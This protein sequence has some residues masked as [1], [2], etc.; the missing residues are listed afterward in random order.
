MKMRNYLWIAGLGLLASCTGEE[1]SQ[2][3]DTTGPDLMTLNR[4]ETVTDDISLYQKHIQYYENGRVVQQK[5]FGA[6]ESLL[7]HVE[8]EFTSNSK[9]LLYYHGDSDLQSK[10]I[11]TYD[12][13]GK[14]TNIENQDP[15]GSVIGTTVVTYNTD[16]TI[17]AVIAN[18][19]G[20]TSEHLYTVNADG[21][22]DTQVSHVG[23]DYSWT[24][25][26]T[27]DGTKPVSAVA[28]GDEFEPMTT[29]FTYYGQAIPSNQVKTVN[30]INN[31]VF[32]F[33]DIT[34]IAANCNHY[35][36]TSSDNVLG[37]EKVF[38]ALGYITET[39]STNANIVT[40]HST[41]FYNE[42]EATPAE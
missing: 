35:L 15:S 32:E 39:T 16:G 10:H 31:A 1:L 18:E 41:Y 30:Q 38:N 25:T 4:I 34:A 19:G 24:T 33:G 9:T 6:D 37:S 17:T 14:L 22:I 27:Y 42:D 11:V 28:E 2:L 7:A 23:T 5:T 3:P 26:L 40:F 29:T 36:H 12:A 8:Y 20:E 13:N 21:L